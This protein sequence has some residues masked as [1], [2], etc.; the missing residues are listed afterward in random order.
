MY[1]N[2]IMH[3]NKLLFVW[4]T[5]N[6]EK[7]KKTYLFTKL[8]ILYMTCLTLCLES[9]PSATYAYSNLCCKKVPVFFSEKRKVCFHQK[10]FAK[11]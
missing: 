10:C 6:K 7:K 8:G 2:I 11:C 5:L 3:S 1:L 9:V 4:S